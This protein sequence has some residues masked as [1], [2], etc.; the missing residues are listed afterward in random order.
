MHTLHFLFF[1]LLCS[2]LHSRSMPLFS[3]GH[4]SSCT[5]PPSSC[6]H[7]PPQQQQPHLFSIPCTYSFCAPCACNMRNTSAYSHCVIS[8]TSRVLCLIITTLQLLWWF[9]PRVQHHWCSAEI[10]QPLWQL[11]LFVFSGIV[12][13]MP[14][15][16]SYRLQPSSSCQSPYDLSSSHWKIFP[17]TLQSLLWQKPSMVS[18]SYTMRSKI[19][20]PIM[21]K[22]TCTVGLTLKGIVVI[23]PFRTFAI[24]RFFDETS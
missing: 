22:F 23:Y 12:E 13:L 16:F 11:R 3:S 21:L 8:S 7:H 19:S 24:Q 17:E 1:F 4:T 5:S 14:F 2:V 9:P 6:M 18:S 10:P 20:P 15:C